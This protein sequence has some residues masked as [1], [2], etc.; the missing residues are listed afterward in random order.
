[1][2]IE[3]VF[4]L[5][6]RRGMIHAIIQYNIYIKVKDGGW[7]PSNKGKPRTLFSHFRSECSELLHT[8]SSLS[9]DLA[10]ES[11]GKNLVLKFLS[12]NLSCVCSPSSPSLTKEPESKRETHLQV[13]LSLGVLGTLSLSAC[14]QI[15]TS[16]LLLHWVGS[17]GAAGF[18]KSIP[19]AQKECNNV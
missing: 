11:K 13:H 9:I 10:F 7:G 19:G 17:S 14:P 15:F 4:W 18:M 3:G 16:V 12:R 1:M 2:Y 8:V 5:K 6:T